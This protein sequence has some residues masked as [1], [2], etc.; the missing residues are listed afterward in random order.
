MEGMRDLLRGNLGRSL[1]A[2]REIDRLAAAWPVACGVA[3]A[4]RGAVVGYDAGVVQVEVVSAAWLQ[5][6]M[7]LRTVL[8]REMGKIAE[9]RVTGIHFEVRKG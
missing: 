4:E 8:V 5:Q 9:V 3:L 2:M 1:K 7:A 6:M